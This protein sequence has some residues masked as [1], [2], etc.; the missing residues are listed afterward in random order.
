MT[1]P[2]TPIAS[3]AA[4]KAKATP[5]AQK[6]NLWSEIKSFAVLLLAVLGFHSFVAKPFYIPSESMLPGLLVGDQ[7]VVSKFPY[8]YS[9]VS[10][11]II[12]PFA[13][14]MHPFLSEDDKAHNSWFVKLPY[15]TGR[16]FGALPERGDVVVITPPHSNEDY[17]K[18]LVGLPGDTIEV[19]DAVLI[20]NGTP[21]KREPRP[22]KLI[23]IDA[24]TK[25]SPLEYPDAQVVGA[26]GK[27]YCRL[28]IVHETLP[29][30]RS[31]DIVEFRSANL[32]GRSRFDGD[33]YGP[34]KVGPN[35]V[36]VM[37][38]NRQHS[39]DS[40]LRIEDNGLGGPVP[41]EN[42]SGRAE[43][44]TYSLTGNWGFRGG[45]ALTSLHPSRD[46]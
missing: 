17:I 7:L 15:M 34:V 39:A 1:E 38:D 29:N 30:G 28:P 36:F 11:T 25:C 32:M 4:D 3:T 35:Q 14:A 20:I 24:N 44:I 42:L 2:A 22:D 21:V 5:Q 10:P 31:Y 9:Y 27:A 13:I 6:F 37:G 18:R 33:N 41:W 12:N 8:G 23:P 45:R 26:D 40:R 43:F 46:K 16:I 19:R